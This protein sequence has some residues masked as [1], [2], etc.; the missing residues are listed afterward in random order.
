MRTDRKSG[1]G[2]GHP[3]RP[4]HVTGTPPPARN[5]PG[6]LH[7]WPTL[8]GLGFAVLTLMDADDGRSL[9][10]VVFLA[11]LIYLGTAILGRPGTVWV[12]F[13]VSV[14]A[15]WVLDELRIDPWPALTGGGVCLVVLGLAGGLLREPWLTALQVPAMVIC[16]GAV[17]LALS[18]PPRTGGLL[19]AAALIAHA[20]QDLLVLRAKQVVARSL[21]EFCLVLDFTLGLG[22]VA[23]VLGG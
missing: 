17:L 21:A 10:F 12:L 15:W 22:I 1:E 4:D 8:L 13:V 20:V 14:A 16:G 18:L 2:D 7:R 19:V 11:A 23:L 6:L 3:A 5:L 9:G